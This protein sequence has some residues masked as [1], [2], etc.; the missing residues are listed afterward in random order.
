MHVCVHVFAALSCRCCSRDE[1]DE[2]PSGD[3]HEEEA[4]SDVEQE[5]RSMVARGGGGGSSQLTI[6]IPTEGYEEGLG[7]GRWGAGRRG[8]GGGRRGSGGAGRRGRGGMGK[9]DRVG[10]LSKG[11]C[12]C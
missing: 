10:G 9:M 4:G 11:W 2:A 1:C 8:E 7:S 6:N 3:R 5:P 12:V